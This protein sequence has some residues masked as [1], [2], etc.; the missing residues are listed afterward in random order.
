MEYQPTVLNY[1]E[2]VVCRYI[3][4]HEN[5]PNG[6][7]IRLIADES[8]TEYKIPGFIFPPEI[9]NHPNIPTFKGF[10]ELYSTNKTKLYQEILNKD[11]LFNVESSWAHTEDGVIFWSGIIDKEILFP[12]PISRIY[13]VYIAPNHET[14]LGFELPV[15]F[16]QHYG[17]LS[18][19]QYLYYA[20]VKT[21][22]TI[23]FAL[24]A[25][26]SYFA[27]TH[28]VER[29][30]RDISSIEAITKT[31][32]FLTLIPFVIAFSIEFIHL[33]IENNIVATYQKS[34][35]IKAL[36]I[37]AMFVIQF[38]LVFKSY[39][40]LL[41]SMGFGVIFY[42]N[43]KSISYR[44]FPLDR[45]W[46]NKG[47]AYLIFDVIVGFIWLRFLMQETISLVG[48]PIKQEGYNFASYFIYVR[49]L[50]FV[51]WFVL[52]VLSYFKTKKNI[53]TT[54]PN[55]DMGSTDNVVMAFKRSSLVIWILP[56]VAKGVI[57]VI[58]YILMIRFVHSE[59]PGYF[60]ARS[61]LGLMVKSLFE[62][63]QMQMAQKLDLLTFIFQEAV[64]TL[65]T[66][67]IVFLFWARSSNRAKTDQK[68]Q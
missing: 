22:L 58:S 63:K 24:L 32:V 54:P 67:S 56:V 62:L 64:S 4:K 53:T 21:V 19:A 49:Q 13:C 18:Y 68:T 23:A 5:N 36:Q 61:K 46:F 52:S 27:L 28:N 14:E 35:I 48:I 12:V 47:T 11:G 45:G 39:T 40:A 6:S 33:F 66:G 9:I 26:S 60:P 31:F 3:H 30:P 51:I 44:D 38:H 37:T 2:G 43:D 25:I 50:N 7:Y 17:N 15:E 10:T 16:R 34:R 57:M 41:F 59:A 1:T 8:I 65:L 55:V 42:Y 29:N 20:S